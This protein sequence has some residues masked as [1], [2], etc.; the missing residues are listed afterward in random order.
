MLLAAGVMCVSSWIGTLAGLSDVGAVLVCTIWGFLYGTV[1]SLSPGASWT[2]LQGVVWLVISTAYPAHGF[3]ALV[4]GALVLAGG[5]L[6]MCFVLGVWRLSGWVTPAF[7]G[8]SETGGREALSSAVL[9][10]W[11]RRI[12]A[13]RAA[14][15]LAIA[16]GLYRVSRFPMA[17]GFQ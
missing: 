11:D 17:I 2:A 13:I 8:S 14:T 7:G 15:V 5:L 12:Q 3:G 6:Q 1:W 4:R 10:R 9:D 16:A